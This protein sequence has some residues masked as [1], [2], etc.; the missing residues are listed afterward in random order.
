MKKTITFS[1]K[2]F[3][4]E[5]E[6]MIASKLRSKFPEVMFSHVQDSRGHTSLEAWEAW[7][8]ST[9]LDIRMDISDEPAF[10]KKDYELTPFLNKSDV[11][12]QSFIPTLLKSVSNEERIYGLPFG[13]GTNYT[14]ALF[15]NDNIF[16]KFNVP[17]PEHEMTW[18]DVITLA[19]KVTGTIDGIP[20]YGLDI[21]DY[22]LLKMQLGIR[23]LDPETHRPKL[24]ESDCMEYFHIIKAAYGIPGNVQDTD[25][26]IFV[27]GR[28][29][30]RNGTVA[31]SID[32]PEMFSKKLSFKLGAV[33]FPQINN[34]LIVPSLSDYGWFL[35]L[36][37]SSEHREEAFEVISYL[38]S[39][40][41]QLYLSRI[42]RFSSLS[43]RKY[44]ADYGQDNPN[45]SGTNIEW[46]FQGLK[47]GWANPQSPYE[48]MAGNIVRSEMERA[49][50]KK[51]QWDEAIEIMETRILEKLSTEMHADF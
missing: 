38:V 10:K 27:Y 41:I 15:Y 3:D 48:D 36:H 31:M 1:S 13:A 39:E 5:F 16:A 47:A 12:L 26:R 7:E 50:R 11:K 46:V 32:S 45:F 6:S 43:D 21:G 17:V 40:E 14:H 29:F 44:E 19:A 33:S 34:N 30:R 8:N 42:G 49:V 2:W 24:R 23:F 51:I 22:S 20:Y 9:G 35:T 28:A 18:D 4:H 25:E 37:P